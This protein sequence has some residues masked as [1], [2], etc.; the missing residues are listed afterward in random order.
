MTYELDADLPADAPASVPAGTS[1]LVTGPPMAGKRARVLELIADG[2][3][4][5]QGGLLITTERPNGRIAEE[6]AELAGGVEGPAFRIVDATGEGGAGRL[7]DRYEVEVV[8]SPDDLTGLGIAMNKAFEAFD[9]EGVGRVRIGIDSLST[10]LTYLDA[11]RVY[12]F[13]HVLAGRVETTGCVGLYTLN[14]AA[15]DPQAVGMLRNAVDGVVDLEGE[16]PDADG[17]G[18]ATG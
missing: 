12:K 8:S 11:E 2:R 1:L 4:R 10:M 3:E 5:G 18:G 9:A 16:R 7:T 14:T 6:Y 15:A 13:L 17:I